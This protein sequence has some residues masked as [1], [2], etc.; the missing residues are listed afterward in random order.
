MQADANSN[1]RARQFVQLL[2][3]HEKRLSG[4][5]LTLVPNWSDAE[6]ILQETKLRLWEQFDAYDTAKDFG[7]W[8]CTIARYQVLTL[9]T[10]A[11]RSR[12]CFSG[13]FLDRVEAEAASAAVE[14]DA[15]LRFLQQCLDKLTEWQRELLRRCCLSNDSIK[16]VADELGHKADSTRK[17]LLRIR[18][19]LYRCI[20]EAMREE[21]K[22]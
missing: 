3:A 4:Y 11:A 1:D 8:A 21:E 22:R 9:R 18:G 20:E 14:S 10:Q 13:E 2:A 16:K 17:S 12:V 6:E 19:W 5:V 7:A 15:R